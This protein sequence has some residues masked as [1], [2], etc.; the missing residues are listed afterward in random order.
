MLT[1]ISRSSLAVTGP[2][3]T[4]RLLGTGISNQATA[5]T[6]GS[7][8]M[9]WTRAGWQQITPVSPTG[10]GHG[11][12]A[13]GNYLATGCYDAAGGGIYMF[14]NTDADNIAI[15]YFAQTNKYTQIGNLPAGTA[16]QGA[17]AC[18]NGVCYGLGGLNGATPLATVFSYTVGTA[19]YSTS[20]GNIPTATQ[21]SHAVA[22]PTTGLIYHG[23]G[24]RGD[25]AGNPVANWYAWNPL[26]DGGTG[27]SRVSLT[28]MPLA[29][30]GAAIFYS[31]TTG[32]IWLV[33]GGKSSNTNYNGNAFVQRYT[34][35]TN[36]WD[37]S[38]ACG[39]GTQILQDYPIQ[40]CLGCGTNW[41]SVGY[42]AGGFNATGFV[43]TYTPDG[44][45]GAPAVGQL[46]VYQ[47]Y[48][49][50]TAWALMS[51]LAD[52]VVGSLLVAA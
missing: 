38:P 11:A 29:V 18:L 39:V 35:A 52:G 43:N 17:G 48:E 50:T 40:I 32:T 10:G 6:D 45:S 12:N 41:N 34:I 15:S 5:G 8:D 13:L 25:L 44:G 21:C 9:S 28:S 47:L 26:T 3:K 16:G 31:P 46:G 22:V 2:T 24:D 23:G 36:A 1:S 7:Y 42:V 49:P 20:F 51:N 14:G 30:F 33:G 37:T 27:A 4:L 19:S